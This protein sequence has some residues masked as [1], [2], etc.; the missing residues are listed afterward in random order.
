MEDGRTG[1]AEGATGDAE[2]TATTEQVGPRV[3]ARPR[4]EIVLV[5]RVDGS[6]SRR[7]AGRGRARLAHLL[8]GVDAVEHERWS[9]ESSTSMPPAP[10]RRRARVRCGRPRPPATLRRVR[11]LAVRD[12]RGPRR[13]H[14]PRRRWTPARCRAIMQTRLHFVGRCDPASARRSSGGNR[15]VS[16]GCRARLNTL[17]SRMPRRSGGMP[18]LVTKDVSCARGRR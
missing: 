1:R 3:R 17:V 15:T 18:D 4:F 7:E 5:D 16:A 10:A 13:E 8:G 6:C 12:G 2:V 11:L 14:R 9:F